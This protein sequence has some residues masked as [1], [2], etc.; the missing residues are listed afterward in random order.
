MGVPHTWTPGHQYELAGARH[1]FVF[2]NKTNLHN[3]TPTMEFSELSL[4]AGIIYEMVGQFKYSPANYSFS[5]L[6]YGAP[7][8]QMKCSFCLSKILRGDTV[9]ACAKNIRRNPPNIYWYVIYITL[10]CPCH[11]LTP[12]QASHQINRSG[13]HISDEKCSRRW[14][15]WQC[16]CVTVYHC[17][18]LCEVMLHYV[19]TAHINIHC[20]G[21][22]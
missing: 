8:W 15:L 1:V 21:Q 22:C 2:T 19:T 17:V 9:R 16:L 7:I 18:S 11:P 10:K 3:V 20:V 6:H 13:S 14:W 5:L 4:P 12:I